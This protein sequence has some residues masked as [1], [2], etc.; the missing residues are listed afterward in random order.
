MGNR[1][2]LKMTFSAQ[3]AEFER[4]LARRFEQAVAR[5]E[6]PPTLL[7]EFW[8]EG[9]PHI[10]PQAAVRLIQDLAR[11]SQS[12]AE[13][14]LHDLESKNPRQACEVLQSIAEGWIRQRRAES[15]GRQLRVA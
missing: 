4:W 13:T 11:V 8:A 9:E 6:I 10:G 5:R 14:L 3:S 15:S 1:G 2:E 7:K 12:Q